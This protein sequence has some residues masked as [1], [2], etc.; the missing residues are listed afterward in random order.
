MGGIVHLIRHGSHQEVGK[1]LSGRSE[2]ALDEAGHGDA[3][4][5]I[6]IFASSPIASIHSS[7]RRRTWE[8][9]LPLAK[10]RGLAIQRADALD[11]IDFG[12]FAGRAFAVLADDPEWYRWNMERAEARCP[13]GETMREAVVRARDYLFSLPDEALPAICVTHCDII[14]GVVAD[15]LGMGLERIFSLECDPGS[16]TTLAMDAGNARL[17]SLNAQAPR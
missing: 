9:G 2:I 13:G 17:V 16:I 14:R 8:T 11:E 6:E 7:P 15:L 4:A 12:G 3:E 10:S 5:L 1:V